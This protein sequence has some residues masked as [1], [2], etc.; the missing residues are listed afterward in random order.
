MFDVADR[1]CDRGCLPS[2]A[3]DAD[4]VTPVAHCDGE[5]VKTTSL[6]GACAWG[7]DE[8]ACRRIEGQGAAPWCARHRVIQRIALRPVVRADVAGHDASRRIRQSRC[9]EI[10]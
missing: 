4:D 5:A 1:H 6:T 2:G 10:R 3:L 9:G 8:I 7:V